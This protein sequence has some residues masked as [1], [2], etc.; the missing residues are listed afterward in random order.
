MKNIRSATNST[1]EVGADEYKLVGELTPED[2]DLMKRLL[3]L[4]NIYTIHTNSHSRGE[5]TL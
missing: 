4:P 2:F 1:Q 5:I 3:L